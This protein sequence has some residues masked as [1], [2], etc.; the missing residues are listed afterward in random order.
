M[1]L[2]LA[3]KS[4][5]QQ[6]SCVKY[7]SIVYLSVGSFSLHAFAQQKQVQ[8]N[9][10]ID[11]ASRMKSFEVKIKHYRFYKPD[12]A[13]H[14]IKLGMAYCH[15]IKD[16][17]CLGQ[18]YNHL[19]IVYENRG[20]LDSAKHYYLRGMTSFKRARN[21]KGI[22][23]E[24]NRLGVLSLRKANYPNA[25]SHF[26]RALQIY[27]QHK[28]AP[29][30]AETYLK[31]GTVYERQQN[32][33]TA[34]SYIR[35]AEKVVS[36]LP[37]S[38]VTLYVYSGLGNAYFKQG[39]YQQ[40][41]RYYQIG[42]QRSTTPEYQSLNLSMTSGLASC[43]AKL[44]QDD[45]ALRLLR[46]ILPKAIKTGLYDREIQILSALGDAHTS[47]RPDSAQ[48]YYELAI[49]KSKFRGD[50]EIA[51]RTLK[52]LHQL[53]YS[54]GKYLAAIKVGN[55]ERQLSDS[56]FNLQKTLQIADLAANHQLQNAKASI[57]TLQVRERAQRT[58]RYGIIAIFIIV[59]ILM[60][61][62]IR[63]YIRKKRLNNQLR[64]AN[65]RLNLLNVELNE[66]NQAKDKI[67]SIIGHDLRS[68]LAAIIGVLELF[69]SDSLEAAERREISEKLSQQSTAAMELLNNL[70]VWGQA[71]LKG[72]QL[73]QRELDMAAI[74]QSNI[75]LLGA[76]AQAKEIKI[77]SHLLKPTLVFADYSHVDFVVRNLLSN[78]IKYS[79]HGGKIEIRTSN[80]T[81]PE[82]LTFLISDSGMGMDS[83]TA[84]KLFRL[85]GQSRLG[86]SGE[87]GT[88][89]GLIICKSFIEA[90]GGTISV[91]S[92][93]QLGTTFVFSLR[94]P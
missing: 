28:Y 17:E 18:M 13:I 84:E 39:Q 78:A 32:F 50:A 45:K 53:H 8:K 77:D 42:M 36:T 14:F 71:Q 31:L 16:Y 92:E 35:K 21:S 38:S 75:Q 89:L 80:T 41:V 40:A 20:K 49:E 64:T 46:H 52:A 12:S 87:K 5:R 88:G 43:L 63:F 47:K 66:A 76:Q 9:D 33:S 61:I 3:L 94:H 57:Q 48:Y 27:E 58:E 74:V 79:F 19:G 4:L 2:N 90:N 26:F 70:L 73:A 81:T 67:F 29:G 86:T 69:K 11:G 51:I 30:I 93:Q 72:V 44:G 6:W 1:K 10:A 37:F 65:S 34:L 15:E 62:I 55:R 24:L 60:L 85:D 7:F 25:A 23:N 83:E 54:R 68:P 22:A 59:M 56:L 82:L 91:E